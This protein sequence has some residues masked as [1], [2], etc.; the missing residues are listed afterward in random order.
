V[1]CDLVGEILTFLLGVLPEGGFLA[2]IVESIGELL[3]RLLQC[4]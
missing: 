2:G 3:G 4:G 1:L